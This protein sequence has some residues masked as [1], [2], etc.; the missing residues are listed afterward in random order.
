M[1]TPWFP[2]QAP[3]ASAKHLGVEDFSQN[4]QRL[5]QARARSVEVLIAIHQV[6][7]PLAHRLQGRPAS[8]M[9]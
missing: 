8:M 3:V 9:G 2:A 6:D 4:L 5:H 7:V 1:V